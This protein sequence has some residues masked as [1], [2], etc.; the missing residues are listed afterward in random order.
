MRR[1]TA[2]LL[3]LL[4]V[5]TVAAGP[6][7]P[8]GLVCELLSRPDLAVITSRAPKFGWIVAGPAKRARQAAYRIVVSSTRERVDRHEGDLWDSKKIQ[9][10]DSQNVPYNGKPLAA[11]SSCWWAVQMWDQDGAASPFSQPQMFRTG[12]FDAVRSWPGESRWVKIKEGESDRW[13]LENRH[14]IGYHENAPA[15]FVQTAPGRYFIDFGRAAFATL[16][17][18]VSC[19]TTGAA[20]DIH[21]GE[22]TAGD[23]RIDRNP[24]GSVGYMRLPQPLLQGSHTYTLALPRHRPR[25]PHSQVLPEHMPEVLPFRYAEI[26]D[27]P[28]ALKSDDVRQ[29]VLMYE[30]NDGA[31]MFSSS[32]QDLNAVWELCKYTLKATPFLGLYIDGNRERMPYEADAYI[33][34]LG[35]YSVDREFAVQ[36]HT[37][38]NLFFHATWPTEWILHSILM[39]WADYMY[40]GNADL[41]KRDYDTIKAKALLALARSDGLIS[42]QTGLLTPEVMGSIHFNGKSLIDIVDWPHGTPPGG[43]ERAPEGFGPGGETDDYVFTPVNTVVNAF[44]NRGLALMGRIAEVAGRQED[45]RLFRRR[46]EEHKKAFNRVFFKPDLGIYTDGEGTGHASLHANMFPLAFGLVPESNIGTVVRFIKSRGMACSVYGAQYLLE[47][48]YEA[49]EGQYALDLMRARTERSWWNMIQQGSTMTMEAWGL[50]YKPNLTWNHAW[51]SAP[52]NIVAR[53]LMGIEPLEPG[54]RK[55]RIRPQLADLREARITLPTIRGSIS[56]GHRTGASGDAE[57]AVTIPANMTAEVYVP[58]ADPSRVFEQGKP[59]ARAVGV[60][61]LR[62][63]NGRCIFEVDSGQYHFETA[64][65]K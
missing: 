36:R 28:V 26:L 43:L 55:V 58:A 42:T 15:R 39:T 23:A 44:H 53:K 37:T 47:A 34:Q 61:Y 24:G 20:L 12:D 6:S 60:R 21:L 27:C 13:F 3:C 40:T 33:Q 57:L 17:L 54:F 56:V 16:K 32:D 5:T 19:P 52:A 9:S 8:M 50:K 10:E 1:F 29:L 31:S 63:E 51:G 64:G 25:Y 30:F 65:P 38:E 4:P 7:A 35:H 59:A 11:N 41:I 46:A 45:A 22:K 18:S 48:L 2:I 62:T 49:G 14:P